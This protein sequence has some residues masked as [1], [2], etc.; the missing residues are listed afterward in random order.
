M[1]VFIPEVEEPE[2]LLKLQGLAEVKIGA[3]GKTYSEEDLAKEM[4]DADAVIITSQFRLTKNII[5][6]A[7]NLKGIV[8]Y[9]SK[10]GSDNV[11]FAAANAR[12]IPIA[13]TE[14]ANSDSVAEFAALLALALAKKMPNVIFDV[15]N[16]LWRKKASLSLELLGKTI[17]IVGLGM[18]GCKVAQKLSGF[19][20]RIVA[21]DPYVS[22]EKAA[23]VGAS[24]IDL[25]TLLRE[26]D[27]VTLHAKITNETTHMIGERE[28]ALMK[29][30]AYLIN[31]ARGALVDE[32]ALYEALRDGRIAG[33]GLDVFEKEPPPPDNP[34]LGLGNVVLTPHISSWTEDALKKEAD[35]AMEEVKRIL[36]GKRPI[37]LANPEAFVAE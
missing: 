19:G 2:S 5:D 32:K 6:R 16:Q 33:A 10:P 27:I 18:I 29:P 11:D 35:I 13:Y 26:S 20:V 3:K 22:R 23:A 24:L 21:V 36:T 37:N 34:L 17:G 12:R 1:K 9:G 30:T 14:G 25:D 31:T 4:A 28:L 15:K 7:R 8:K